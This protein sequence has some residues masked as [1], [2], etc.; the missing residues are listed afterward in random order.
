MK[1]G[2]YWALITLGVLILCYGFYGVIIVTNNL[3]FMPAVN[4]EG[5]LNFVALCA[6]VGN[7]LIAFGLTRLMLRR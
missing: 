3:Q 6:I 7:L 4:M 5:I 2:I 1:K